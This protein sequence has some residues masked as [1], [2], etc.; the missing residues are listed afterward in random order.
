M[1]AIPSSPIFDHTK[2]LIDYNAYW[3]EALYDYMRGKD[4]VFWTGQQIYDW[5]S[6]I[7][8]RPADPLTMS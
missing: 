5:Y 4:V 1:P 7:V 2:V 6:A 8:P 3:I